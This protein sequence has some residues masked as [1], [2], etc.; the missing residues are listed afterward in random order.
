MR[1]LC[2][3]ELGLLEEALS[4]SPPWEM[5]LRSLLILVGWLAVVELLSSSLSASMC[6]GFDCVLEG[7]HAVE[8]TL[9]CIQLR[10]IKCERCKGGS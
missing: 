6:L 2:C 9:K 1:L 4:F 3:E 10:Y 5:D 8:K 7:K